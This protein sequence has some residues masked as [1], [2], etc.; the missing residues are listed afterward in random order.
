MVLRDA[1][2]CCVVLRGVAWCVILRDAAWYCMVLRDVLLLR[3]VLREILLNTFEYH[4][5]SPHISSHAYHATARSALQ[6]LN[7]RISRNLGE[8]WRHQI[9]LNIYVLMMARGAL[10]LFILFVC[11]TGPILCVTWE[12]SK[13]MHPIHSTKK[14]IQHTKS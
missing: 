8:I 10:S 11:F 13:G 5:G 7:S 4:I 1:A 6:L 2:W 9:L 3:V 14:I 12:V